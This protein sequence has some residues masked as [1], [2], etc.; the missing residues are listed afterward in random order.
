MSG[1]ITLTNQGPR[2]FLKYINMNKLI[3]YIIES[4]KELKKVVWPSKKEV[5][6]HTILVIIIS[7]VV[8]AFIGLSDYILNFIISSII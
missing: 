7:L 8:A 5:T 3:N 4:K 2:A 6:Q 1:N